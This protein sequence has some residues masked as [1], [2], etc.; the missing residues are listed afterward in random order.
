MIYAMLVIALFCYMLIGS[1]AMAMSFRRLG[2]VILLQFSGTAVVLFV[3]GWLFRGDLHL[4]NILLRAVI[5]PAVIG[6]MLEIANLATR[7]IRRR[8]AS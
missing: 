8:P 2:S 3:V 7:R 5:I 6:L 1:I 4:I